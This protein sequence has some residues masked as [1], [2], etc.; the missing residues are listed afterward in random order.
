MKRLAMTNQLNPQWLSIA[1]DIT[2]RFEGST[3]TTVT[4]DFDG[5]GI[6]VGVLQWNLGQGT[7]QSKILLPVVKS[8][9]E[10][11]VDSFFPIPI[12]QLFHMRPDDSLAFARKHMLINGRVK[13]E[14]KRCWKRFLGTF[15]LRE[16]QRIASMNLAEK[17]WQSCMG[18]GLRSLRAFCW[19]F[20]IYVQNGSLKG[21]NAPE[22]TFKD[23]IAS[24]WR[25]MIGMTEKPSPEV[26]MPYPV[27]D[28][29]ELNVIKDGGVNAAL[30]TQNPLSDDEGIILF[31]W[32]IN[33]VVRNRWAADVIS[34]KGT[35]AHKMGMVHG[36]MYDLREI[37]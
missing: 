25:G 18:S 6:S 13:D 17:A 10:S 28:I 8:Y 32:T 19:F 27:R 1:L 29:Y 22:L 23:K 12:S 35:I 5:Q 7:L 33:R 30:W 36:K 31:N 16:A 9:G 14:W 4:G 26:P 37:L 34:R 2:G 11:F 15:D 24:T 3:Y 21:I 20:D